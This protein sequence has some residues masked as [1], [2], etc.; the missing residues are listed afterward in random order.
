MQPWKKL[1][2]HDCIFIMWKDK[3]H[4]LL[5]IKTSP[6]TFASTFEPNPL[7]PSSSETIR[8]SRSSF[9]SIRSIRLLHGRRLCVHSFFEVMAHMKVHVF[10]LQVGHCLSVAGQRH[11]FVG[12]LGRSLVTHVFGDAVC[13]IAVD[14]VRRYAQGV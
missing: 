4:Y 2:N 3:L 11:A 6:T 1:Q 7:M 12:H 8:I 5:L 14:H 9:S 10:I 13:H